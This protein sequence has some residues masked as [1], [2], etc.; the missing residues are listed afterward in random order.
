MNASPTIDKIQS[1]AAP[2]V[3]EWVL[4]QITQFDEA[5]T[6]PLDGEVVFHGPHADEAY[7]RGRDVKGLSIVLYV[8]TPQEQAAVPIL[9]HV[10]L[11]L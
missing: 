5:T 4:I 3:G 9:I 1:L 10:H 7:A 2:F 6:V 11:A 8:P